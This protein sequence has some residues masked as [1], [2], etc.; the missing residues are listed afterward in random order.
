MKDNAPAWTFLL[1]WLEIFLLFVR[2][3][4]AIFKRFFRRFCWRMETPLVGTQ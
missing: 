1:C 3:F 2:Q 4:K